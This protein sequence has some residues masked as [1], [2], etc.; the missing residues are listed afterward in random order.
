MLKRNVLLASLIAGTFALSACSQQTEEAADQ[1]N[2]ETAAESAGNDI[3][4]ATENAAADAGDAAQTGA[5]V[6]SGAAVNAGEAIADGANSAVEATGN[7]VSDGAN[8]VAEGAQDMADNAAAKGDTD[9]QADPAVVEAVDE[10]Q[11]Y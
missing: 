9:L 7:A 10:D 3:A 4:N 8:A 2:V 11:Q 1:G 6:A 5:A